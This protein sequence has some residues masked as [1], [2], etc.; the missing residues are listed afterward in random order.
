M[1]ED[2]QIANNYTLNCFYLFGKK[3][4]V[5][6]VGQSVEHRQKERPSRDCL[7]WMPYRGTKTQ[8]LLQMSRSS[9]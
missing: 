1:S 3:N 8:T 9:C 6:D 5:Q 2:Q 4:R 7:T